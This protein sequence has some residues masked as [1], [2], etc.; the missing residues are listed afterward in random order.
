MTGVEA[1][2]GERVSVG[3]GVGVEVAVGDTLVAVVVRKVGVASGAMVKSA[4]SMAGPLPIVTAM[5]SRPT[6]RMP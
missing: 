2:T 4:R 1:G 3:V 6:A 5:A